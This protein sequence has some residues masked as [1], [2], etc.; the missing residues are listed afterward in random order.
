MPIQIP[1]GDEDKFVGIIDLVLMK[2]YVWDQDQTGVKFSTINVPSEYTEISEKFR[3]NLIEKLSERDDQI[4]T[5]FLDGVAI[6]DAEIK[7]AIRK[8]TIALNFVPVLCGA[9]FKNK[10]VQ[11]L[12][13]AVIDYLY[14]DW[15]TDRKSTRLNSSHEI[16]SRMP[17]SA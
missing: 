4:L 3:D 1:I 7:A 2:A 5:K 15:E 14:R 12:L 16:P 10:G 8:G 9:S 17:S 6:T 11:Q 13:D